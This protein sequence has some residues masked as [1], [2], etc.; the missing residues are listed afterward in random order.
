MPRGDETARG[1]TRGEQSRA[2]R[3]LFL[4]RALII[5]KCSRRDVASAPGKLASRDGFFL[6]D[7]TVNP[8]IKESAECGRYLVAPAPSASWRALALNADGSASRLGLYFQ[9][10]SMSC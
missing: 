2:Q 3:M 6:A 1:S 8:A 10:G 5:L 7:D 4:R 9:A